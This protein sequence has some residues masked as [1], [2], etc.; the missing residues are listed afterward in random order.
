MVLDADRKWCQLRA[1]TSG[2]CSLQGEGHALHGFQPCVWLSAV[3][4]SVTS[5]THAHSAPTGTKLVSELMV[6]KA[7]HSQQ[8]TTINLKGALPAEGSRRLHCLLYQ[9]DT[10]LLADQA[11]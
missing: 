9:L 11:S 4:S 7:T 2:G 6:S 1:I 3:K 8:C 10:R 5:Q